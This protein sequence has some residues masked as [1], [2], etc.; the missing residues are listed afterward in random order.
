MVCG[1]AVVVVCTVVV[2]CEVSVVVCVAAADISV[3]EVVVSGAAD[4]SDEAEVLPDV[5][6]GVSVLFSC[7]EDVTL[8]AEGSG[9]E[10]P[11]PPQP[12][13]ITA[14]SSIAMIFGD[15]FM[16]YP[17]SPRDCLSISST[18]ISYISPRVEQYSRTF[19]GSLVW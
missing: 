19:H 11:V 7:V 3:C 1:A 10:A 14:A 4:A 8:S 17:F 13:I 15:F 6:S 2:V 18:T 16:L 5:F 12:V 9:C